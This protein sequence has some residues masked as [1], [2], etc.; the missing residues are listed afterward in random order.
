MKRARLWKNAGY[1]ALIVTST[2]WMKPLKRDI[3]KKLHKW[4][5]NWSEADFPDTKDIGFFIIG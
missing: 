4:F 1:L 5:T 3:Q 2:S